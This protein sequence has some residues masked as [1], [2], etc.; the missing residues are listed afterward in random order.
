MVLKG[1]GKW[2]TER[3]RIIEWSWEFNEGKTW[4]SGQH[5]TVCQYVVWC[6]V[7]FSP[8]SGRFHHS[9]LA[10]L[11]S[12]RNHFLILDVHNNIHAIAL[13]NKECP[14]LGCYVVYSCKN[15]CFGGTYRLNHQSDK[16]L[17]ASKEVSSNRS[18]LQRN[19]TFLSLWWWRR[20]VPPKRRFMQESNGV[21]TQKTAFFIVTAVKTQIL[22]C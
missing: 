10:K 3:D 15:R 7:K 8:A 13:L 1:T 12:L 19:T 20:Y 4:S 6:F 9:L 16:K 14:V 2:D 5:Y 22:H 21:T 18:K 17:R 11:P